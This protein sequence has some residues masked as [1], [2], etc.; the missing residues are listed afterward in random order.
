M[1]ICGRETL[2]YVSVF[3]ITR[4][5]AGVP[6]A[7]DSLPVAAFYRVDGNSGAVVLDVAVGTSGYVTMTAVSGQTGVYYAPVQLSTLEHNQYDVVMNYAVS[8]SARADH[9]GIM[10]LPELDVLALNS[11][12]LAGGIALTA[13]GVMVP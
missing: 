2:G 12:T 3:L 6:V 11:Q 13:R 7:A 1:I 9:E 5:S 10:I 4:N 8:A